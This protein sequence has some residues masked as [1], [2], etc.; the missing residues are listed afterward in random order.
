MAASST[1]SDFTDM[2]YAIDEA[3]AA[4]QT[5]SG[6]ATLAH[7]HLFDRLTCT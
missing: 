6:D 1:L 4:L 3:A 7:A 2:G 5:C